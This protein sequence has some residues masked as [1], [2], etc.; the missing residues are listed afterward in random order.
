M[1]SFLKKETSARRPRVG[2]STPGRGHSTG[3]EEQGLPGTQ[4]STGRACRGHG[5]CGNVKGGRPSAGRKSCASR[6]GGIYWDVCS[7][8]VPSAVTVTGD[9]EVVLDL[10]Q[11][12][13]GPDPVRL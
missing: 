8:E 9:G 5:E 7:R 2:G 13:D 11:D 1:N 10:E 6:R 12:D 4:W 3:G